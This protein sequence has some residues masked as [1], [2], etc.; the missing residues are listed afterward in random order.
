MKKSNIEKVAKQAI[1]TAKKEKA[2]IVTCID[3]YK[4]NDEALLL[5]DMLRYAKEAG[6]TIHFVPDNT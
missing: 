1:D 2:I 3:G 4:T 6:V 5:R